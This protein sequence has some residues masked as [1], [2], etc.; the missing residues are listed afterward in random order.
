M[1][2]GSGEI[3]GDVYDDSLLQATTVIF[4]ASYMILASFVRKMRQF[5]A[6]FCN[7]GY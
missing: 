2:G 3:L 6:L 7:A 1:R 4:H 5:P